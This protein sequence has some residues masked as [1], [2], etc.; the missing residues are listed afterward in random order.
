MI[1]E[2]A[3]LENLQNLWN[4]AW[5]ETIP[6]SPQY[7]KG[8]KPLTEYLRDWAH[9]TPSKPAI[10]FYG[11]ELSY[12]ELDDLSDRF[13]NLLIK[14]GIKSGDLVAIFMPNCPQ[15]SIAFYGILKCGAICTP[16]SPLSKAFELKHQL[17]DSGAKVILCFD[18]LLSVVEDV[19]N[20]T[21]LDHII[22]TS[23]SEL[24]PKNP[25]LP[26]PDLF[27]EPKLI[28][29]NVIDFYP[30]LE[31]SSASPP[32]H[33]PTLE[34]IAAINYTGGTTGLPKGCIHTHGDMLYTC[35]SF[36][37][38]ILG[39]TDETVWINFLPEFWIAGED[40]GLL[41]PVFSGATMVLLAR[42]DVSAFMQAVEHYRVTH[43]MLLVDNA[44]EILCHPDVN[45]FDFS[46]L[47]L[48]SCISFVKKLTLNYRD[49]WRDLTGCIL[50]ETAYGMTETNT[51]DTFTKG[52]QVDNFDL[53]AGKTFVGIPVV[54]TEIKICDFK[55]RKLKP[56]GEDGE[57]CIR[58]PSLFKGYWGR[59]DQT[60][61]ALVNGWL[62]T[63]DIGVIDESGFIR[64]L[65]RRKEMLKVNGMSV[66]PSELETIF[67]E[68]LDIQASAVLGRSDEKK[69]QVPVA[70]IVLK[71]NSTETAESVREWC[72]DAM[73]IYKVPEVR[74]VENLPMTATGKVIKRDLEKLL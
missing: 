59:E 8:Q 11:N 73:A 34:D 6:R 72:K 31:S 67:G 66:F 18:Q 64:Y 39:M 57:I 36:A 41:F 29:D 51:C 32:K 49:R 54:G 23:F 38:P 42:W 9:E 10:H 52:F 5:P 12:A 44:D 68:H 25:T 40:S 71:E 17:T 4:K 19:K 20:D 1:H 30:A 27:E 37:S 50:F 33:Q 69:G 61:D 16:I 48:T 47:E 22:M 65:G 7:P 43:C 56:L 63:G 13:A 28:N 62:H 24:K 70:F 35:A 45:N 3:Y 46:S 14:L 58:T 21:S 74:I 15:F 53:K 55:S 2:K 60:D 26:L